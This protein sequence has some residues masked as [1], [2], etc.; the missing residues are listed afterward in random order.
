MLPDAEHQVLNRIQ[1]DFKVSRPT[2]MILYSRGLENKNIEEFIRPK[3][4]DLA[5]PFEMPEM[6]KAVARIWKAIHNRE[7][8]LVHGDFD[9][10]GITSTAL[11]SWVLRENGAKVDCFLPHRI[12]DGY[13]LT[14]ESI[15]KGVDE[16]K[17][18]ITVD[19]GITSMEGAAYAK[20]IG[21]D[22][23]ITDHH[24]PGPE[25]PDSYAI[26]NPKLHPELIRWQVLAGVGGDAV[27]LRCPGCEEEHD[28][29]CG[30]S[31]LSSCINGPVPLTACPR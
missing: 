17:L 12:D 15:E 31:K 8:I 2:A 11:L 20:S 28:V 18:L 21:L 6:E 13:G 25:L 9:T 10:D 7:K 16:H 24:Q 5:D 14:K 23:I 27:A 22:L 30:Q 3:L 19:C 4:K 1:S 26:I 29:V